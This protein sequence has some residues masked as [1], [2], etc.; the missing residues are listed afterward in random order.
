MR[1]AQ[2]VKIPVAIDLERAVNELQAACKPAPGWLNHAQLSVRV[3]AYP[4]DVRRSGLRCEVGYRVFFALTKNR[5]T[6][7]HVQ[8]V[9]GCGVFCER[10]SLVSSPVLSTRVLLLVIVAVA[11]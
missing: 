6:F 10:F 1:T 5:G 7:R 4:G 11:E 9:N 8:L 2:T 3:C